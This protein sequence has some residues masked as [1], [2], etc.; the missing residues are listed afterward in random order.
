L[1]VARDFV[2]DIAN[3]LRAIGYQAQG[4]AVL[5]APAQTILQEAEKRRSDLIL[6]GSRGRQGVSRFVLGSVA[7]AVLHQMPCPV[8]VF[9]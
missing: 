5:G 8:L 7:H 9:Q 6:M 2:N 3:H 4:T 1:K